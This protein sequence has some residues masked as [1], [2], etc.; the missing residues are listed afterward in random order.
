MRSEGKE[1]KHAAPRPDSPVVGMGVG[2]GLAASRVGNWVEGLA[3]WAV[4]ILSML[5]VVVVV[6]LL[7]MDSLPGRLL[8]LGW[9]LAA[10]GAAATTRW[11]SRLDENSSSKEG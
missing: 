3:V 5:G 1:R 8:P 11:P 6:G 2:I 4:G 9:L 7:G 10:V